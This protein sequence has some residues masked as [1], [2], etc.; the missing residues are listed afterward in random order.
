MMAPAHHARVVRK[1]LTHIQ[2]SAGNQASVTAYRVN[3]SHYVRMSAAYDE[4]I[5]DVKPPQQDR[6]MRQGWIFHDTLARKEPM[7]EGA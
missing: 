4:A 3:T 2:A 6:C 1:S 5:G 7:G